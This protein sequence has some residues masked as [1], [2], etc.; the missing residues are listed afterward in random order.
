MK[1]NAFVRGHL[2]KN[3]RRLGFSIYQ[4]DRIYLITIEMSHANFGACITICTIHP[5]NAN[6]LLLYKSVTTCPNVISI[7][8]FVIIE[9]YGVPTSSD[10]YRPGLQGSVYSHNNEQV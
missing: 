5:K 7:T 10:L 9:T 8:K 4:S 2:Q 6:Y 3:V 1:S